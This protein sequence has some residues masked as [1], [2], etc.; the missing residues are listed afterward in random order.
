MSATR[1]ERILGPYEDKNAWRVVEIDV[2]GNRSGICSSASARTSAP[3]TSR[4][5]VVGVID[6]VDRICDL[7]EGQRVTVHAMRG[8][9]AT[10]TAERGLAGHLIAAT[11]GREDKRT[12]MDA[13]AYAAPGSA[14]PG[15]LRRGLVL[16]NGGVH[17]P[18]KKAQNT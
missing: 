13:D 15:A 2:L 11:L 5:A 7:V 3:R 17:A 18:E 9:L 14:K 12:T 6:Q 10:L 16:L 1:G 8:I 4:T